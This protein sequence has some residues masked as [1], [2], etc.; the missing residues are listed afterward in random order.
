MLLHA[1]LQLPEEDQERLSVA[2]VL[3]A[4]AHAIDYCKSRPE[5]GEALG[6]L[7]SRAVIDSYQRR[8]KTSRDYPR[9]KYEQPAGAPRILAATRTQRQEAQQVMSKAA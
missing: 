6:E 1:R 5:P 7:L 3:H 8:N 4:F 9:K 2:R